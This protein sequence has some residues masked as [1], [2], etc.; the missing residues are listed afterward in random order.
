MLRSAALLVGL[1]VV[2]CARSPETVVHFA[3]PSSAEAW[4][5][6]EPA[7]TRLCALP[8]TVGLDAHDA[9]VLARRDGT[10]FVVQQDHLGPGAWSGAVRVRYERRPGALALEAFSGALVNAGAVLLSARNDDRVVAGF[11]LSGLGTAGLF[12]SGASPGTPHEELW[13]QRTA[14]P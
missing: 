5:V 10:L 12:A 2:G 4:E 8:C 11:L 1:S 13:L 6:R 9:V 3:A 14:T 7:G